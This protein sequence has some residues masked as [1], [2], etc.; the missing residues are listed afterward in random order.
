MEF[1]WDAQ[2]ERANIK[3]HRV[4]FAEAVES[5]IDPCGIQLVDTSHSTKEKRYYWVGKSYAGRILT[6]RFTKRANKIR[7]IG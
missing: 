7:I 4:S 3:K 5:F 6:T 2:K 1:E